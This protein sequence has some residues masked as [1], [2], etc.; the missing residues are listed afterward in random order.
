MPIKRVENP[1][2]AEG[3]RRARRGRKAEK[4]TTKRTGFDSVPGSGRLDGRKGDGQR[5]D[6]LLE[7]KSTTDRSFNIKLEQLQK[8][9]LEARQCGRRPVFEVVFIEETGRPRKEGAWV[10]IREEDWREILEDR[11]QR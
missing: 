11:E 5:D 4:M 9:A 10:M 2:R 3:S 7:V 1:A 6:F 8:I